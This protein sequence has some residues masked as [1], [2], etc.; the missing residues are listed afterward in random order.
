MANGN[1]KIIFGTSLITKSLQAL[2]ASDL[3]V[4]QL[5]YS[6]NTFSSQPD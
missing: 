2:L 5:K 4:V 1:I 6:L 3:P